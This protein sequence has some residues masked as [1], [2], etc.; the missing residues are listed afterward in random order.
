MLIVSAAVMLFLGWS[1]LAHISEISRA[2][3]EDV[4][5]SETRVVQHLDG[6]QVKEIRVAERQ[7]VQAGDIL[8]VIDGLGAGQDLGELTARQDGARAA[9]RA[10]ACL[11]RRPPPGFLGDQCRRGLEGPRARRLQQHARRAQRA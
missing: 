4:P 8:F 7:L 5:A 2:Y 1:A 10:A 6:G 9:D 11:P 3:G